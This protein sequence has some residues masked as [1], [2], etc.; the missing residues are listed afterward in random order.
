[1]VWYGG[2]DL[3]LVQTSWALLGV[4]L[5]GPPV[6]PCGVRVGST[7]ESIGRRLR[8]TYGG[9]VRL[10]ENMLRRNIKRISKGLDIYGYG[11]VKY[12]VRSESGHII[13]LWDQAYYVPGL[14]KD[15]RIIYPHGILKSEGYK[16]TS[17]DNFMMITIG[18]Q[19]LI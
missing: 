16:G 15:L 2:L 6:W 18:M 14:P 17:I 3:C 1:M 5:G 10:E 4:A 7:E 8:V 11:I 9:N 12:S 13:A 19:S